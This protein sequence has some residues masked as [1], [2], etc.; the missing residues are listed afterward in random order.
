MVIVKFEVLTAVK[1]E[2][3]GDCV[4]CCY[5]IVDLQECI[6]LREANENLKIFKVCFFLTNVM[7]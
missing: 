5:I 2:I 1:S 4:I 3:G 7:V 6:L